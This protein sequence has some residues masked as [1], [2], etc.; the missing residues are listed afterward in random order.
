MNLQYPKR[1]LTAAYASAE[2]NDRVGSN[3]GKILEDCDNILCNFNRILSESQDFAT[4]TLHQL[5]EV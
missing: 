1:S 4:P 5:I 2:C 3:F